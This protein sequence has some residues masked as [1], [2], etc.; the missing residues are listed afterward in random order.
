MEYITFKIPKEQRGK[1]TN[2][3]DDEI[4]ALIE[5]L[6]EYKCK[7]PTQHKEIRVNLIN[8]KSLSDRKNILLVD[9][10][11]KVMNIV[12]QHFH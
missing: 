3:F 1:D 6:L 2:R 9:L 5:K 4:V 11:L 8:Y 7:T 10:F 12:V